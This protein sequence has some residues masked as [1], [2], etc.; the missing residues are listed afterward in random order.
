MKYI[1]LVLSCLLIFLSFSFDSSETQEKQNLS[2]NASNKILFSLREG[3]PRL[4][5]HAEDFT[6]LKKNITTDETL[7][8]WHK[9]LLAKGDKILTS[10]PSTY[11]LSDRD[12]ILEVSRQVVKRIYT[13]GLLY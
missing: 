2:A 3:H 13:L 10:S 12:N 1:F 4:L 8:L 7:M 6:A 5:A 11:D 9:K